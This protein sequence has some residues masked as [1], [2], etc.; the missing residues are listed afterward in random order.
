[1]KLRS[2]EWFTI[3]IGFFDFTLGWTDKLA[4]LII[5]DPLFW[6]GKPHHSLLYF[7]FGT[8]TYLSICGRRIHGRKNR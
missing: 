8:I 1:M 4:G 5:I 3:D 6:I 7:G 2:R